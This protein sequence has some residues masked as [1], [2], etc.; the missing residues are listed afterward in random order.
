MAV[1]KIA[2]FNDFLT[3]KPTD[4]FA[5]YAL[6]ME[7]AKVGRTD[8]AIAQYETLLEQNPD[9]PPG[10]FQYGLLLNRLE[11]RAEAIARLT[12]GVAAATRV[13]DTHAR[14]EMQ[15]QMDEWESE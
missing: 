5:R 8:E 9:Y 7:L 4:A 10:H 1:D 6:A 13:N 11:R 3:K 12:L 2:F 15:A 14:K